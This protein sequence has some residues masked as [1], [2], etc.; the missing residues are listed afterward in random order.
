MKWYCMQLRG[1]VTKRWVWTV[2]ISQC[3]YFSTV[4]HPKHTLQASVRKNVM[5]KLLELYRD[6]C[7]KCSNGTATVNTHYE[8]IPAKLI[9][10]CFDNDVESFRFVLFSPFVHR[11]LSTV[12]NSGFFIM[13]GHRIWNSYFLKNSFH[14][15]FLQKKE[16]HIGLSSFLISNRSILRLW[17]SSFLRREG[18]YPVFTTH[19]I[20]VQ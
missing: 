16:Q 11:S 20:L 18:R 10:L 1:C 7:D 12:L 15:H 17:T 2:C 13:A 4:L 19:H 9:V 3:S 6:Y 5:H 14:H 8:Q